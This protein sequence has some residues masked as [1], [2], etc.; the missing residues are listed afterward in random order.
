MAWLWLGCTVSLRTLFLPDE[1]RYV[2]VAWEMAHA[3]DWLTP[4]LDGLPFFHKPPLFYWLTA[5]MLKLF[6]P[7]EWAARVAGV[8]AAGVVVAALYA[9]VLRWRGNGPA[10]WSAIVL[11][12]QPMFFIGAQ[13]ANLDMLVAAC[14]SVTVLLGAHAAWQFE[15]GQPDRPALAG[16]YAVMA[17]GMLAKGLIGIVLPGLVVLVWLAVTRRWRTMRRLWWWP[18]WAMFSLIAVPWLGVMQARHADFLHYFIVVQHFQR[19]AQSGFNSVQPWWFYVP[20]LLIFALP[21][22]AWLGCALMRRR[23]GPA[24]TGAPPHMPQLRSLAWTWLAV[25]V[26][27]FSVPESK[28]LG[29]ILPALTP[30]AVLV[31]EYADALWQRSH[32]ARRARWICAVAAPMVCV[33]AIVVYAGDNPKSTRELARALA[34]ARGPGDSVAVLDEYPYD[35]MFYLRD[36]APIRVV[37]DWSPAEVAAHD[38]WRKELA[39]AGGFDAAAAKTRLI[40]AAQLRQA[41]C[42]GNVRWV[43]G[44][45]ER[46]QAYPDLIAAR[47]VTSH[48]E[49]SLWRVSRAA[50]GCAE[51]VAGG[52]PVQ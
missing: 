8:A 41:V 24:P 31:V 44:R 20:V 19:F 27:F 10:R 4:T 28:L 16:A 50:S 7:A 29:Y 30:L 39:D 35:L 14:I 46:L 17:L 40:D 2:G 1:G 15:S 25:V 45:T 36:V 32:T 48:G 13:F 21:W 3:S 49:R 5:A 22:S 47:R 6:G 43:I 9:V 11:A 52:G 18:G 34:L 51:P 37:T 26:V 42:D 23:G 12:S 33:G 38:D